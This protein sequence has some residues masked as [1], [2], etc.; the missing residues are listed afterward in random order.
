MVGGVEGEC[1]ISPQ[2][3]VEYTRV[4]LVT[5][6]L[7]QFTFQKTKALPPCSRNPNL[8]PLGDNLI[9]GCSP[10][11]PPLFWM[12]PSTSALPTL[13]S[14][15]QAG[16]VSLFGYPSTSLTLVLSARERPGSL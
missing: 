11:G 4:S 10:C 13:L 15:P 2:F 8:P 6:P 7:E 14:S 16:E 12:D 9:A 5:Q 1:E 3:S